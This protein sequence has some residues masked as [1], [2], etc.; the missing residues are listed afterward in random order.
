MYTYLIVDDETLIRKGVIKKLAPL[1]HLVECCGEADSGAAAIECIEKLRPDIV[2]LDMQ[3][4]EMGGMDLLPWLN[5]HYPEISLI[6]ISA[7]Q[8]F[9]YIKQAI[10]CKAVDYILKPFSREQIQKIMMDVIDGLQSRTQLESRLNTMEEEK[11][12]ACFHLELQYLQ[13]L[14]QNTEKEHRK[15]VSKKLDYLNHTRVFFL[16]SLYFPD[17]ADP[18]SLQEWLDE[19]TPLGA[20]LSIPHPSLKKMQYVLLLLPYN[21]EEESDAP[22]SFAEIL[23]LW[24]SQRH[25]PAEIGIS[26]R[27]H[28]L[29]ELH[30]AA[31]E[32][33]SALDSQPVGGSAGR[34]I[35][36]SGSEAEPVSVMV[37]W[38]REEEFLFR[39]ECGAL[40]EVE[41][42]ADGLFRFYQ[43]LPGCTLMTVKHHCE[44]LSIRCGLILNYYL[45]IPEHTPPTAS[46]NMQAIISTLH[47][48]AE[49]RQYYLQFFLNVA[50]MVSANSVYNQSEPID[51]IRT[52]IRRNYQNDLTQD[53]LASLFY[54][55]RSYISQLFRR[56]T[57]GKFIDYL[58]DVWI[59]K[60][61]ELLAA[62][63]RKIYQIA[64]AVGYDN[65]KYFFR[66][67]HKKTGVTP[68][69]YRLLH[70]RE[71]EQTTQ[72]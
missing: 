41:Q 10:S 3:M 20:A 29:L 42:L 13:N 37:S 46:H 68:E 15:F 61:C 69:E 26:R 66:L 24:T 45:N 47:S 63:D 64:R 8:N 19:N 18:D 1:S 30:R 12:A 48:L 21:T 28:N 4:P 2:I 33:A 59:E 16:F 27:H 51:R 31:M 35:Y 23:L 70:R 40:A 39:I 25:A 57:G 9:D 50:Q 11:E 17:S 14:I 54:M 32:S 6:V 72:S 34:S 58:N 71:E 60:A 36:Q 65:P 52:Y 44:H 55:N 5:S 67:F 43:S 38:D 53:F 49:V 22:E 62:S 7:H 56:K